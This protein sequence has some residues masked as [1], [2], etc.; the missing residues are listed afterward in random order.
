MS[1]SLLSGINL[2]ERNA[3]IFYREYYEVYPNGEE[4]IATELSKTFGQIT[5]NYLTVLDGYG[6]HSNDPNLLDELLEESLQGFKTYWL[7]YDMPFKS[8]HKELRSF[9]IEKKDPTLSPKDYTLLFYISLQ[10]TEIQN[11]TRELPLNMLYDMFNPVAE[12]NLAKWK[13]NS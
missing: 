2:M 10:N 9:M 11:S 12:A 8:L 1:S 4:H 7:F 5:F 13:L 3:A 6:E